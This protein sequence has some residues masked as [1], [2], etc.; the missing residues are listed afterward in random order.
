[1]SLPA[2]YTWHSAGR[3]GW[4]YLCVPQGSGWYVGSYCLDFGW[5]TGGRWIASDAPGCMRVYC[6]AES[7][8]DL[9]GDLERF[10][11][12]RAVQ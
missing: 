7:L 6:R 10:E 8:R 4:G 3:E 1:M 9:L 2:G 12:S 5:Y 11:H